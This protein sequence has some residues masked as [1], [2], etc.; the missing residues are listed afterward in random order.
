MTNQLWLWIAFSAVVVAMLA[1]DLGV[2]HRKAHTVSKKEA[3]GW[4]LVWIA[5]SLVFCGA[6]SLLVSR[7][8]GLEFLTGWVIEK[9]LSVDNLFI[10]ILVFSYF[11]VEPRHQHRILF[12]G[13]LGALVMRGILI[14]AG[15]AMIQR[16]QWI[17][18]FFG[19]FLVWT[20]VKMFLHGEE[21]ELEPQKNPVVQFFRRHFPVSD[22]TEGERFFVVREGR[23]MATPLFLVVIVV[24]TTDLVFATDSLPAIFGLTD[25]PFIVYTSNVFAIL[26]LRALYFL[27]AGVLGMFRFLKAGLAI[28]L[29]FIGVKMLVKDFLHIPIG[30]SLVVVASVLAL[31]ILLS[32]IAPGADPPAVESSD[33]KADDTP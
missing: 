31:S 27:L 25:D 5:L 15:T 24:E 11:K 28:V 19:A 8:K 16:F 14:A 26:G 1:L 20:A 4:S 30:W 2:F 32:L 22:R 7:Q 9:S 3:L 12:W 13:I 29:G 23:R 6:I 17:L 21:D 33:P 18:Y 10:F